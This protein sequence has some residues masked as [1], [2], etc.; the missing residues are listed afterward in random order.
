MQH[1][2]HNSRDQ[3]IGTASP[4]RPLQP[5][6]SRASMPGMGGRAGGRMMRVHG[7]E[8][9]R[10]E[11]MAARVCATARVSSSER[12]THPAV[13]SKAAPSLAAPAERRRR[14]LHLA[15][16]LLHVVCCIASI[17]LCPLYVACIVP[18]PAAPMQPDHPPAQQSPAAP[19]QPECPPAHAL[20]A[21]PSQP[22]PQAMHPL[23]VAS[24]GCAA[25]NRGQCG[26]T[27]GS[28]AKR[29]AMRPGGEGRRWESM[30]SEA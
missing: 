19:R 2:T 9:G 3:R 4:R 18:S 5:F 15:W 6:W 26:V 7:W 23:A 22:T 24:D 12:S 20:A 13:K 17:E 30:G 21:A 1:S 28:A 10:A 27:G 25:Q 8:Q 11:R 29:A 14:M 16:R